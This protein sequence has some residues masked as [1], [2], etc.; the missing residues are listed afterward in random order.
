MQVSRIIGTTVQ[1]MQTHASF[2]FAKIEIKL[3]YPNY[4]SRQT[5]DRGSPSSGQ[6]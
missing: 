3:E 4:G 6:N 2:Y 1:A 5:Q